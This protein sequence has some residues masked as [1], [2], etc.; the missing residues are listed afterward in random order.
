MTV[1][2]TALSTDDLYAALGPVTIPASSSRATYTNWGRAFSCNPLVVFEPESELQCRMVIELAR[3]EGVT[4]RA[5]GAGHSPS[6][7]ACT[8]G[9]MIRTTKL[10]KITKIDETHCLVTVQGGIILSSLH[11]QLHFHNLALSNVGS[12]SDQ[13]MAGI[14][15]TSTHGSGFA[16][17]SNMSCQ[18]I[19]L[20]LLLSDGSR[21]Q[22]S[23][24]PDEDPDLFLAT[25]C[26]LGST[27]FIMEV[28][29][30]CE[31][32]FKLKEIALNMPI[33]DFIENFP[34]IALSAEHVRCWW[35]GQR[36]VVRVSRCNRTKESLKP[37]AS[38]FRSVFLAYHV[39]Q[40]MLYLGRFFPNVNTWTARFAS[41]IMKDPAEGV[42]NSWEIFNVDCRYPQH[43]TEW[44]L[45]LDTAPACLRVLRSWIEN[46][47]ADTH[48][49]RPHFPFEIR[50]SEADDIW[51][52][53]AYGRR[54]C[55]IGIAQY[56]PFCT[57]VPFRALFTQF[58]HIILAHGG[59]P[60]WAKQ[61]P[62]GPQEFEKMYEKFGRFCE[63]RER[64]DKGGLWVNEYVQRSI[65]GMGDSSVKGGARDR[66]K[67][68]IG[69][70][71]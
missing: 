41:W 2:L 6:D 65:L 24:S 70:M 51:L 54:T 40:F 68:R 4:L 34:N 32:A 1:N 58:E 22:C 44:A 66:D 55:W 50:F 28:T 20:V 56:K 3:R 27:G 21:V 71:E 61:H 57:S 46:Q 19:S 25:L 47:L 45:P 12:I 29:I 13:S 43:T 69:E 36:G 60:H 48:G 26:G 15:A 52:S 38:W 16:F 39:V 33:D 37:A 49:L 59:R 11:E 7:I 35:F 18:V 10:D 63:V 5:G 64:V 42:G 14:V 31:R 17:P 53:P 62:L 30:Q 67:Y 9:F 8:T 23:R